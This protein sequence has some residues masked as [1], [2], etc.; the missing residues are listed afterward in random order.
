[1]VAA[2]AVIVDRMIGQFQEYFFENRRTGCYIIRRKWSFDAQEAHTQQQDPSSGAWAG[3]GLQI[4]AT[5]HYFAQQT[6]LR[7]ISRQHEPKDELPT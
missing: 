1:M 5:T 4:V 6:P 7:Y 3:K 2:A